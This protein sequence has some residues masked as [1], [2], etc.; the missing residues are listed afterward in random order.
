QYEVEDLL[1]KK[2]F[3]AYNLLSKLLDAC[4]DELI[5]LIESQTENKDI[6]DKVHETIASLFGPKKIESKTIRLDEYL[7]KQ[8]DKLHPKYKHRNCK[9]TLQMDKNSSVY[10]PTQILDTIITGII[11]NAFE[12]TPDGS[13]IEVSFKNKNNSPELI[14]TDYGIGFTKE[15][16]LLIFENFFIPP[17][18]IDYSTKNPFDFNA[19]GKGFGL[20]RMKIF[21]E[22]YHFKI[23][24]E[25]IRCGVIP[26]EDDICPGD[27]HLCKACKTSDECYNSGG[28]SIHIKFEQR[29]S[30]ST[31]DNNETHIE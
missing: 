13:K 14:V 28:T 11:R 23:W 15:K 6:I 1:R 20:L 21:S 27:I 25:S 10:I 8:I 22:R 29:K 2:D 24:I 12:Y 16:L 9:L 18:S 26:K 31:R 30:L 19:G 7:K 3:K 4:K 17:E 5:T